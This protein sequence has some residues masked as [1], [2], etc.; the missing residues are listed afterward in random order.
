MYQIKVDKEKCIGC[1]ACANTCDNFEIIEG[2]SH[3]KKAKVQEIGCSQ[4]AADMCP[5]QAITIKK[6]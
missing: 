3:V 6:I 2:K 5:V 4:D 1:G